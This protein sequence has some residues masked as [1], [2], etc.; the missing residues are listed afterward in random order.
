M[1]QSLVITLREGVEAALVI[2]IAVIY[3][4]KS[5][6][7]H[8]TRVVYIAL[9]AAVVA[10]VAAAMLLDRIVSNQEAFEGWVLL[11]AAFLVA[12]VVL[13]M[14]RTARGLRQHIEQRLE[15]ISTEQKTSVLGIFLFVFFM[16]F[17][18]GAETVLMLSAVSLNSTDLMNF[19]GGALGLALA[20]VFGILFVR[21]SARLDLRKFFQ[22]TT[23]IL[24]CVVF[25][26]TITGLHELS[27]AG[28]LPSSQWEMAVIGPIVTNE[29]FFVVAILALA[30]WMIL[31]D[32]RAREP[33]PVPP[34]A[35]DA[36]SAVARRKQQWTERR[37]RLWTMAV[38]GSAFV[39]I[40]LVTA[41]YL[42]AKNQT[43]L[44]P[45]TPVTATQGSIRIPVAV[46][47]DGNL[48]RFLYQGEEG[49]ARF[50]VIR[51]GE[52]YAA[53]LDACVICGSQ[54]YYQNGPNIFC[55]NCSAAIFPPS[56][57]LTGGCNP[58]PLESAVEGN[59]LVIAT[60]ELA[61]GTPLFTQ[62]E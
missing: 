13:W 4:S 37:E 27:E 38:C 60:S 41:E 31:N 22:V 9:G 36:S 19:F 11:I 34:G 47:S 10:S 26:L 25:Q 1:I 55:R 6:R 40:L 33:L 62:V 49:A 53:A 46:V 56:I 45:S 21:G 39:F 29:V 57:G 12:T 54:G 18:E 23:V 16:V 59:E 15:T 14:H 20:V 51:V 30:S 3:L 24:L 5:G 7:A 44:S 35:Q 17:R 8:L 48:H 58:I 43:A 61:K 42:Y 50:V 32:W 28:V 2:A 52:R